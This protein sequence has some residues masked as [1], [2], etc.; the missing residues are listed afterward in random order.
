MDSILFYHTKYAISRYRT[1]PQLP[2]LSTG[3]TGWQTGKRNEGAGR[4]RLEDAPSAPARHSMKRLE[5]T[6]LEAMETMRFTAVV[7]EVR[8]C[9]LLVCDCCTRQQVLVNTD[10]ACCFSRGDCVQIE[11][12]GAMTASLP[13]QVS[14]IRITRICR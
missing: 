9:Q 10:Q 3:K 12:S 8:C 5:G 4:S 13:P 6:I 7:L 14:A 1:A 2:I 11:H